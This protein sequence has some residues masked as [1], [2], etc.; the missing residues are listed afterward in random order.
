ML[1]AMEMRRMRR[2]IP[3]TTK[4]MVFWGTEPSFVISFPRLI[5]ISSVITYSTRSLAK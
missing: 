3:S 5:F 2:L 1:I 4:T